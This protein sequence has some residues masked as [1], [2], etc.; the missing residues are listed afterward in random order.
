MW[1][2]VS[3]SVFPVSL[4]E[5]ISLTSCPSL[6]LGA[7]HSTKMERK[8]GSEETN[9]EDIVLETQSRLSAIVLEMQARLH[10]QSLWLAPQ[11]GQLPSVDLGVIA[12]LTFRPPLG[13]RLS[14]SIRTL[15]QHFPV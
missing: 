5:W 6:Q 1:S 3:T 15:N 7:E 11:L 8:K 10:A 13:S 9:D 2:L 14:S 4:A 12:A